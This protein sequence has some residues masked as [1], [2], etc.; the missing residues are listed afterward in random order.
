MKAQSGK[1]PLQ[2]ILII[3]VAIII[4]GVVIAM[5]FGDSD[6]FRNMIKQYQNNNTN[7][8]VQTETK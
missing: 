2:W 3:A 1:S 7:N 6:E 4:V 5:I 8:T